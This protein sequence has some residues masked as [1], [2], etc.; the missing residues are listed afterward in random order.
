M[1]ENY[2]DPFGCAWTKETFLMKRSYEKCVL[3]NQKAMSSAILE[4]HLRSEGQFRQEFL[5]YKIFQKKMKENFEKPFW[6]KCFLEDK[7][8]K[9]SH[10]KIPSNCNQ[11]LK[12]LFSWGRL[13]FPDKTW[14]LKQ[15][16]LKNY[17]RNFATEYQMIFSPKLVLCN[18]RI[19]FCCLVE[20][21]IY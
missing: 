10:S 4:Q 14:E 9:N 18:S 15:H 2:F 16:Q 21:I 3:C 19:L 13:V 20:K 8:R 11:K 6:S 7:M 5:F 1:D 17:Q 12:T